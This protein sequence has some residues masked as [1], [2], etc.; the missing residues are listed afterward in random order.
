MQ[1]FSF[2]NIKKTHFE[3]SFVD[4]NKFINH[5]M[6]EEI[7]PVDAQEDILEE[8]GMEEITFL[9]PAAEAQDQIAQEPLTMDMVQQILNN[10][11]I[12]MAENRSQLSS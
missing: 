4:W 11:T 1:Y 7:Q 9:D 6:S 8:S 3:F 5:K 2:H 10:I 12:S